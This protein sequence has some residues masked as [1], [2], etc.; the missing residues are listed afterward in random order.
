MSGYSVTHLDEIPKRDSWIPIRDHFDIGAFGVNAYH[1]AEAGG[2]LI[3][4]TPS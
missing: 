2:R 1:A 4:A 3:C